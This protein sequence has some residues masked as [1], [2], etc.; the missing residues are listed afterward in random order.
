MHI[1]KPGQNLCSSVFP[2][3]PP[4]PP[5]RRLKIWTQLESKQQLCGLLR[6]EDLAKDATGTQLKHIK[7]S[8]TGEMQSWKQFLVVSQYMLLIPCRQSASPDA[9]YVLEKYL[10]K[11][12]KDKCCKYVIFWKYPS[13]QQRLNPTQ[14]EL[15]LLFI[16][17]TEVSWNVLISTVWI[18]ESSDVQDV[19]LI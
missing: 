12:S 18:E 2:S 17:D 15:H 9:S 5:K 13:F 4:P 11:G 3:L 8:A 6:V 1:A 7:Y 14:R 16:L 19:G 10:L